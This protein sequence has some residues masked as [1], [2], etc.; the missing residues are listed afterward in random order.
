MQNKRSWLIWNSDIILLQPGKV[1]TWLK[2]KQSSNPTA[3]KE[4]MS[5]LAYSHLGCGQSQYNID[6][7][8]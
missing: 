3:F 5:R 8:T 1:Y 6:P 7:H 2:F 4:S